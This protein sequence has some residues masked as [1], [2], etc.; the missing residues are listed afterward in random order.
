MLADSASG[1]RPCH[2]VGG[3]VIRLPTAVSDELRGHA[4]HRDPTLLMDSVRIFG[5]TPEKCPTAHGLSLPKVSDYA[6][7]CLP[8]S[9]WWFCPEPGL[10]R[11]DRRELSLQNAAT[12]IGVLRFEHTARRMSRPL[13]AGQENGVTRVHKMFEFE[14]VH[15]LA[16][17]QRWRLRNVSFSYGR[18]PCRPTRGG[19]P[20]PRPFDL[21]LL[22]SHRAPNRWN[23]PNGGVR[24]SSSPV[25]SRGTGHPGSLRT[26]C[27]SPWI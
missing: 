14:Q 22:G 3:R 12:P 16:I 10:H 27:D 19:R 4:C 1:G 23:D 21:R 25:Q 8:S 2:T 11:C 18:G 20:S 15:L 17:G 24:R 6:T 7:Y 13:A 5:P 26:G 9:L